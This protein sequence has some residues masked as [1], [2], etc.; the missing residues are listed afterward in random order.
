MP[1]C[2]VA[3]GGKLL[4][5]G[6]VGEV[7]AA[8]AGQAAV[9]RLGDQRQQRRSDLGTSVDQHGVQR[10]DRVL[11]AGPE[12][13]AAAADVPVGERVEERRAPCS[14]APNRS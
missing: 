8:L 14:H 9:E 7:H 2:E 4:G 11:I 12:P 10:V 5:V 6:P 13:V 3:V 1:A